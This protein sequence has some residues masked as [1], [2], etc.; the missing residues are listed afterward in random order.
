MTKTVEEVILEIDKMKEEGADA[1]AI[2]KFAK[3]SGYDVPA[4]Q[5][6]YKEYKDTGEINI[7]GVGTSALQGLTFGFS[8][9]LGGI[10]SALTG[11]D[12]DE[13]VTRQRNR[14]RLF[15]QQ[16]PMLAGAAEMV[17]S[18]PSMLIPGAAAAR[19]IQ[20][21]TKVGPMASAALTAGAEGALYGAGK[22]EGIEG[23]L[24][25]TLTG[26][27][28]SA[29]TGGAGAKL[30]S[31]LSRRAQRG[32][33]TPEQRAAEELAARLPDDVTPVAMGTGAMIADTSE[34]AARYLRGIRSASPEASAHIDEVF[35]NR[36]RTQHERLNEVVA[37]AF[38]DIPEIAKTIRKDLDVMKQNA[39]AGYSKAYTQFMDMRSPDL[40]N[41]IKSDIS[42]YW[43][44]SVAALAKEAKANGDTV[45]FNAYKSLPKAKEL[46]ED[47][48]LPLEVVDFMKKN[49]YAD[50]NPTK[51][52]TSP[53]KGIEARALNANRVTMVNLADEATQGVYATTRKEFA[54]PAAMEEALNLGRKSLKDTN[55]SAVELRE[56]FE[57]FDNLQEKKAFTA[58]ALQSL[59]SQ[60][61]K[62]GYSTDAVT[63]LLKSPEAEAKLRAIMPNDAAWNRFK[64]AMAQEARQ[65]RTKRL[66][67]GGSNTAD[68]LADKAAAETDIVESLS[69]L[70]IDPGAA[71][72]GETVGFIRRLAKNLS[73]KLQTHVDTHGLQAKMLTE[74]D[75]KKKMEIAKQIADARTN[76][77]LRREAA[78]ILGA[79]VGGGTGAASVGLFSETET[80]GFERQ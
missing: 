39:G 17:G 52:T 11:G 20:A 36:F 50:A 45:K 14:M 9:E 63:A 59:F 79:R 21:A 28:L 5:Q 75:P 23:T 57:G 25:S 74:T 65:V 66:V 33:M 7:G 49:M 54:E 12:Y 2:G 13:Y 3:G 34:E 8:E 38:D 64:A 15:E 68:K 56:A 43:D 77:G 27:G 35:H 29:V 69:S 32:A 48:I 31:T 61:S 51:G 41:L 76:L 60:I 40:A 4:L 24:E 72:T 22:G 30:A 55:M 73:F 70:V 6:V 67:T 10:A 47:S 37:S 42:D 58:G 44:E 53:M 16:N 62:T 46:T 26:A 1:S 71:I 78:D 80:Q 19:G 18:L